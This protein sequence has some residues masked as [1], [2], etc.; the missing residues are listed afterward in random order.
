M[1]SEKKVP[2]KLIDNEKKVIFFSANLQNKKREKGVPF[3]VMTYHPIFKSL[4]KILRG[5]MNLLNMN[6]EIRKKV[7][8]QDLICKCTEAEQLFGSG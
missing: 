6:E 8:H 2:E 5:N 4:N 7:F 3:V 1:V